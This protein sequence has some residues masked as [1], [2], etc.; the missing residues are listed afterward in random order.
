M[1][2]SMPIKIYRKEIDNTLYKKDNYTQDVDYV[3]NS[4]IFEYDMRNAGFSLVKFYDLLP[5]Y[6]IDDLETFSKDTINVKIG[7]LQIDNPKFS[8]RLVTAF[9]DMRKLF[10]EE[11]S[12]KETQVLS[13]KKDAI[14]LVNKTCDK[15]RFKNVEFALKNRYTSFHKFSRVELY[16]RN[17][18]KIL[19]IK[20]V[21]S[22]ISLHEDY[23]VKFLKDIF[24][25]LET[26]DNSRVIT[27][28]KK[29]VSD[30]KDRSLP[31]QYYRELNSDSMYSLFIDDNN[32]KIIKSEE[33]IKGFDIDISYNYV[34]YILPLI[35]RFF[36]SKGV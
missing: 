4:N 34:N 28:I 15:L 31:I 2:E 18:S 14:F 30:Y 25:T 16:Y 13:V 17:K 12:I 21:G 11:N 24:N 26:S 3:I 32:D 10:F 22:K 1:G 7:L 29:F 8:K 19:D 36:F 27:K 23:M 35:Q 20:G 6:T 9:S 33:T 5:Q